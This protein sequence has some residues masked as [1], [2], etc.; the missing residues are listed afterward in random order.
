[1]TPAER[2]DIWAKRYGVEY[3]PCDWKTLPRI[4]V[5]LGEFIRDCQYD[6]LLDGHNDNY[7]ITVTDSIDH[8]EVGPNCYEMVYL[9]YGM[10]DTFR[11][12][13]VDGVSEDS[14]ME[15]R[16]YSSTLVPL[17]YLMERDKVG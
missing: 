8:P 3:P 5:N 17:G 1:M 6:G 10:D 4:A 13:V 2:D 7:Y 11:K 16:W 15:A 12:I 9:V 14:V